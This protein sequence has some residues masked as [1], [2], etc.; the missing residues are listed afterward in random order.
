MP[1]EKKI[2]T[3]EA[4]Y[5]SATKALLD[6]KQLV[7]DLR[8]ANK[9][10]NDQY[11]AGTITQQAWAAQTEINNAKIKNLS[12]TVN[13]NQKALQQEVA[14][15]KGSEGAY[16]KLN[17]Q[18]QV[19]AQKAKDLAA[20]NTATSKEIK[21]A[22]DEAMKLN[23]RL[24]NIDGTVG[25]S[26]R[27]VA[28]YSDGIKGLGAKF[29]AMIG[30]TA[31]IDGI[32]TA[33][34]GALKV[35]S[36]FD[37]A[38]A[39]VSAITGATKE[40]MTQLKD[41]AMQYGVSTKFTATEVAGLETELGKLG[42]STQQIIDATGGITMAAAATGE[43]LEKT[44][45]IV[46]SVT[47]AF[48]LSASESQR[49]ADV[50]SQSF[51]ATALGLDNFSE[52]IKYVAPVAKQAGI[53]LEETTALLGVLA[54]NGI[55]GSMAGTALRQIMGELVGT[56]GNL[57]EK[58]EKLA[59]KGL[60]LAGAQDEV[61][62]SAKTSLL[63][64][65]DNTKEIPKLT[66][67]FVNS[68]GAS[69]VAASKMMDTIS[70]KTNYLGSTWESFILSIE[71]GDG[72]FSKA[73][74]HMLDVAASAVEGAQRLL[75]SDQDNL[76][77]KTANYVKTRVDDFK[78]EVSAQKDKIKYT[79]DEITAEKH[80]Y[81]A[82]LNKADQLSKENQ[83]TGAWIVAT[84]KYLSTSRD[85]N[86]EREKNL[87]S[88]K[89]QFENKNKEIKG[90][91]DSANLSIAYVNAIGNER[92]AMADTTALALK[93]SET[94]KK[95][96]SVV[97]EESEKQ[98]KK[99]EAAVL[100]QE[101]AEIASDKRIIANK[102]KVL[103]SENDI[104]LKNE[105]IYS[106]RID[107]VKVLVA[108]ELELLNRR[109]KTEKLTAEN[110]ESEKDKIE[111]QGLQRIQ[112]LTS[113]RIDL[114]ISAMNAELAIENEK[115][116]QKRA[117]RETTIEE[118]KADLDAQLNADITA[119]DLKLES[120]KN[121]VDQSEL[122]YQKYKTSQA[123]IDA[124]MANQAKQNK[125][126]ELS[127]MLEIE[128]NNIDSTAKLK[129][130]K[131]KQ[132]QAEELKVLNLTE[133]QK[134]TIN[135]KYKKLNSKIDEDAFN[136]KLD[137]AAS[138]TSG[139]ADLL[140]KDTEAG[141]LASAATVGIQGAQSAFKTGAT[142][143]EYFASGNV[144][145]GILAGVETGIIVANTAKS[146]ADIYKIDTSKVA[147]TASS[148][149][150]STTTVSSKF[151]TGGIAGDNAL[152]ADSSN[153]LTVTLLKG[154]RILSLDQTGIFNSILGNLATLGG[155][156]SIT[157]NVGINTSSTVDQM[158]SAFTRV[159]EKMKAPQMGWTEFTKQAQRQQLLKN[160]LIV[161]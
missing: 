54:N 138:V 35:V 102:Y 19:A 60:N 135:K 142:A 46:G 133:S 106:N 101:M 144:P 49:V 30:V 44:A 158:E 41:I 22:A 2:I 112:N 4:D 25:Q 48:G 156:A 36:E 79:N 71:N 116:K 72:R 34:S 115:N 109:A 125:A 137:M 83:Q 134:A 26:Q 55:K 114:L 85:V 8:L 104:D 132:D 12:K 31:I 157:N 67:Q 82:K 7:S 47:M 62:R 27:K 139:L 153:E 111:S 105:D 92:R 129:K 59:E 141:K 120:D 50:M 68:A 28:Q 9:D 93:N 37:Q 69:E 99:K 96:N 107:R 110:I 86:F 108:D 118:Q 154:E 84:Q 81:Q 151:H 124:Q 3:I 1:N 149:S 14:T 143:A 5:S 13:D 53:S 51:N 23:D 21:K 89:I 65:K 97:S 78:K 126:N 56:G 33:L 123:E 113:K 76:K 10:L 150:S 161:R 128:S 66:E 17:L 77:Q 38:M 160:N 119:N 70:G 16:Q 159:V 63:V 61:G 64:L 39:N 74:K 57:Q 80:V 45:E 94:L 32:A 122:I 136:A 43:S 152:S 121:Y 20:S 98:R 87:A 75:G 147:E 11:K 148:D 95:N 73:L 131:L 58:L 40:Q 24:K 155:A 146:I 90:L 6:S 91:R 42:Y 140:G 88:A 103:D 130:Q 100:K 52:S 117:G 29:M 127:D 18:Y 145:M 15:V